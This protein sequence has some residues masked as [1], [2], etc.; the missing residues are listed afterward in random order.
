MKKIVLLAGVL[1]LAAAA[2]LSAQDQQAP[3]P[4]ADSIAP[5][6]KPARMESAAPGTARKQSAGTPE[7]KRVDPPAAT[8][9]QQTPELRRRSPAA[10]PR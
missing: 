10:K 1:L 7:A 9:P 3:A 4:S 8:Q 6:T 5:G 2:D